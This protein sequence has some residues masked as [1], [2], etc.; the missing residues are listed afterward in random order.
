MF[1]KVKHPDF[2]V[3]HRLK[4][5][6]TK[7]DPL[8]DEKVGS[9]KR[10]RD[11]DGS[12][13]VVYKETLEERK[14]RLKAEKEAE[15][16]L[17][18][19]Q[20]GKKKQA[21]GPS[22]ASILGL[23]DEQE[24]QAEEAGA[25]VEPPV[26]EKQAKTKV[27]MSHKDMKNTLADFKDRLKGSKLPEQAQAAEL[28][29]REDLEQETQK[30]LAANER[31]MQELK[32]QAPDFDERLTMNEIW[33]AGEGGEEDSGDW[34]EGQGLKF[35]T[36]ADKAFSM[37]S[38]RFKDSNVE[39]ENRELAASFV[40]KQSELRMA[41]MRRKSP[42][43]AM[44]PPG[45]D[46]MG[47]E[48]ELDLVGDTQTSVLI[49]TIRMRQVR[50]QYYKVRAALAA[51]LDCKTGGISERACSIL[52]DLASIVTDCFADF[53]EAVQSTMS[54][55]PA[56]TPQHLKDHYDWKSAFLTEQRPI[57]GRY[58]TYPGDGFV[59]DLGLNLTGGQTS[60]RAAQNIWLIYK[61]G[62]RFFT[63]FW[64]NVAALGPSN[65]R[66]MDGWRTTA[67]T[68]RWGMKAQPSLVVEIG[69]LGAGSRWPQA[70]VF[71]RRALEEGVIPLDHVYSAAIAACGRGSQ[72][73]VALRL[74][75][76]HK[77]HGNKLSPC[78][79]VVYTA[80]ITACA[81][82]SQWLQ[83]E[84]VLAEM[85]RSIVRTNQFTY[86]AVIS[87]FQRGAQWE[88]ALSLLGQ[89]ARPNLVA[90]NAVLAACGANQWPLV[91][92]ILHKLRGR[93]LQADI[94]TY[95]TCIDACEGHWVWT[96][97]LLDELE[98]DRL[99]GNARTYSAAMKSCEHWPSALEF[100]EVMHRRQIQA[101]LVVHNA[102]L[103]ACAKGAQWSLVLDQL[104]ALPSR[105]LSADVVTYATAMHAAVRGSAWPHG[106]ALFQKMSTWT[107]QGSVST[108]VANTLLAACEQG[109]LWQEALE[110]LRSQPALDVTGFSSVVS[111]CCR[112]GLWRHGVHL[113]KRMRALQIPLSTG[114]FAAATNACAK[115][116]QWEET[117]MW[118]H[119]SRCSALEPGLVA[120]C[121]ST[122]LAAA[123]RWLKAEEL[124][125]MMRNGQVQ[126]D[127]MLCSSVMSKTQWQGCA[128]SLEQLRQSGLEP[129]EVALNTLASAQCRGGRWRGALRTVAGSLSTVWGGGVVLE[130]A[131][132][133]GGHT[134]AELG[135]CG[136]GKVWEAVVLGV[137]F[138]MHFMPADG[139]GDWRIACELLNAGG[140]RSNR[141]DLVAFDAAITAC[142]AAEHPELGLVM[143]W[144]SQQQ[145][146]P[147][148]LLW[149][150]T[151]VSVEDAEVIHA[152][153][154]E[155][156]EDFR[157]RPWAACEAAQFLWCSAWLGARGALHRS[158]QRLL[159]SK[160][161]SSV[162]RQLAE[163]ALGAEDALLA[164]MQEVVEEWLPD[165]SR[166]CGSSLKFADDG[167][168][169]LAL[170]H[171][172]TLARAL[173]PRTCAT[174][175]S[176]LRM[177]GRALDGRDCAEDAP[178][179][180][181]F[182]EKRF[183]AVQLAV[184][185]SVRMRFSDGA[186][187][188]KPEG[189]EVY[190]GHTRL[191]L[192][193]FA[194]EVLKKIPILKDEEHNRGFL[195]RLDVP[196]SGLI[197]LA[198]SY[199]AF[200]DLQ[201]Q[202]VSGQILREYVA[203][204]HGVSG[205]SVLE[206][207]QQP[208]RAR[209]SCSGGRGKAT[210]TTVDVLE[211]LWHPVGALSRV[212]VEITTGRKHQIR[213]QCAHVGHP[214]LR[215]ALYSSTS[216]FESDLQ[217]CSRNW[218]H[219]QRLT[220]HDLE[221][222]KCEE[223]LTSLREPIGPTKRPTPFRLETGARR[224]SMKLYALGDAISH[225]LDLLPIT[226]SQAVNS[227]DTCQY[228]SGGHGGTGGVRV[229]IGSDNVR[230]LV[231]DDDPGY[232]EAS[233][234]CTGEKPH[235]LRWPLS[236]APATL[237]CEDPTVRE[238]FQCQAPNIDKTDW[239][240]QWLPWLETCRQ[241]PQKVLFLGLGGGYYQSYL[242]SQCP[243]SE[244]LTVE[245]NPTIVEA[246][247]D[248][249]GFEGDVMLADATTGMKS[250]LKQDAKFDAVISDM[251]QRPMESSDL[252]LA[253]KLLRPGGTFLFQWCYG[254]LRKHE[255]K[256][257]KM[258]DY[259]IDVSAAADK[260][261][262]CTFYAAE[263]AN[264]ELDDNAISKASVVGT[265]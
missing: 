251:G 82:S 179:P 49:G 245:K 260:D 185:P 117:L 236:R 112:A 134:G 121:A 41:E 19:A 262:R 103:H 83:A 39:V 11:E 188:Y 84:E 254:G 222:K 171:A 45:D 53:S 70:L 119:G 94:V 111:A 232:V 81:R 4:G 169:V 1:K 75:V 190:G 234:A 26:V 194:A 206:T 123:G 129:D 48:K 249:F 153:C 230:S 261:G 142:A 255:M 219:R 7:R 61:N 164:A 59:M 46:A 89:M 165:W 110:I 198:G 8:L 152:A 27:V 34:L 156:A 133:G 125:Q 231:F 233:V 131:V 193:H 73:E 50:V 211:H 135:G 186:V 263:K 216:T 181:G 20:K 122:G 252:R 189:W 173:R 71:A 208:Q 16:E 35:H 239:P 166:R 176:T 247:R 191:Q 170:L 58:A 30:A 33:K 38:Q 227:S 243:G 158:V 3:G 257:D 250:L 238:K 44:G 168:Y 105:L 143:L 57:V 32:G 74:L 132:A 215:D 200:Y 163:A 196:S 182:A 172:A 65:Q 223:L 22:K 15:K 162:P 72:W 244:A 120:T 114:L 205:S 24:E 36:T 17:R 145:R 100:L 213:S 108:P 246:A 85:Q 109:S 77:Q 88:E 141:P 95:T 136:I 207:Q 40:K 66:Q 201:V 140:P 25:T 242:A 98:R 116:G 64:S 240:V 47:K 258:M 259:F 148:S 199:E 138:S 56:W 217:L 204:L 155:A 202:L 175:R 229:I 209:P 146:K 147:L 183:E 157:H 18:D 55:A 106:L 107:V 226:L 60:F 13:S 21:L 63:Y 102:C 235:L 174:V 150:L 101:N 29:H 184:G 54:W 264:E 51:Q 177:V 97:Q 6:N 80:A 76:E 161:G 144:A 79:V 10:S 237:S 14:A 9:N 124:L 127:T 67:V 68:G 118:L 195:H 214:I 43:Y 221:G 92:Q 159:A 5:A 69:Q 91:L 115:R 160:L 86:S 178:N 126:T 139:Q 37:A 167:R 225:L 130:A 93:K 104:E 253:Q 154:V 228:H 87:A 2:I 128:L 203:L 220:F 96:L 52:D 265:S 210:R 12:S 187:L 180:R 28:K 248:Y 113:L 23:P 137:E 151:Q 212:V 78:T 149:A 192:S 90:F 99:Q 218:L 241:R 42:E 62:A 224:R 31:K 197:L 256:L